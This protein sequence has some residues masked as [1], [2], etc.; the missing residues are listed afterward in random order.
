MERIVRDPLACVQ[1]IYEHFGIELTQQTH[2]KMSRFMEKRGMDKRKP[3]IYHAEDYGLELDQL[4]PEL[5]YYR[6]FYGIEEMA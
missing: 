4:W 2:Q 6:D 1:E 5:Q 3:H